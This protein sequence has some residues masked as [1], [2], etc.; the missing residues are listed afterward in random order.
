[1]GK[2]PKKWIIIVDLIMSIVM[3]V[4][5]SI[6]GTLLA[7]QKI[8]LYPNL[9]MN[10]LISFVIAFLVTTI[11]PVPK[12]SV[13]FAGLFRIKPHTLA[14]KLVGNIP[15]SLIL[16]AVMGAAMIYYNLYMAHHTEMFPR[17]FLGT[18]LPQFVIVY[19]VTFIM[20]PIAAA[21]A[22]KICGR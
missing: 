1:M 4:I 8:V 7:H 17:A 10:I 20:T 22:N 15:V 9:V 3:A 11:L 5:M 19:V 12:I 16:T 14:E 2:P 13:A 6:S 18:F 21:I